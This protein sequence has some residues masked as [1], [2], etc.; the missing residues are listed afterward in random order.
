MANDDKN[1]KFRAVIDSG[2][3]DRAISGIQQKMK[4]LQQEISQTQQASQTVARDPV[5]GKFASD[6]FKASQERQGQGLQQDILKQRQEIQSTRERVEAKKKELEVLKEEKKLKQESGELDKEAVKTLERKIEMNQ[7]LVDNLNKVGA[8]QSRDL[9]SMLGTAQQAG[10]DVGMGQQNMGG[11]SAE[12]IGQ[13][14]G[15]AANARAYRGMGFGRGS[16]RMLSAIGSPMAVAG[17]VLGGIG[18][19]AST[20]API[21]DY[22]ATRDNRTALALGQAG[23]SA[24]QEMMR[25]AQGDGFENIMR[26]P[27]RQMG[28]DAAAEEFENRRLRDV[29]RGTPGIVGGLGGA[30]AGAKMGAAVGGMAGSVVPLVG[31]AVGA[32]GGAIVGGI[33]GYMLGN[34][35][36]GGGAGQALRAGLNTR[37]YQ[38]ELMAEQIVRGRQLEQSALDRDVTYRASMA[39]MR[40]NRGLFQGFQTQFGEENPMALGGMLENIQQA[41]ITGQTGLRLAQ[42][43]QSASGMTMGAE[44]VGDIST[45]FRLQ[46]AGL[47]NAAQAMGAMRGLNATFGGE[48]NTDEAF[49]KLFSE[50]V[51]IGVDDSSMVQELRQFTDASIRLSQST[52]MG[53]EEAAGEVARG[54]VGD[55]SQFGLQSQMSARQIERG[56]STAGGASLDYKLAF[57]GT[58]QGKEMLG[59]M[60]ED[61]DSVLQF[62]NMD[63]NN[64]SEGNPVIQSMMRQMGVDNIQEFRRRKAEFDLTGAFRRGPTRE[65]FRELTGRMSGMSSEEASDFLRSVEGSDMYQQFTA[66]AEAENLAFRS[67]F[68]TQMQLVG[69]FAD[70]LNPDSRNRQNELASGERVRQE[71]LGRGEESLGAVFERGDAAAGLQA[72]RTANLPG[73]D[74]RSPF[75]IF[76]E[77]S[78]KYMEATDKFVQAVSDMQKLLTDPKTA[79]GDRDNAREALSILIRDAFGNVLSE[80]EGMGASDAEQPSATTGRGR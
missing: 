2:E 71:M 58:Q 38:A 34:N 60:A 7:R 10:I 72:Q 49:K 32:A 75:E 29:M 64:I 54:M 35:I 8:A 31:N 23:S 78:S 16:A 4:K 43:Q 6:F 30:L 44:D 73:Q 26:S 48:Q 55:F 15:R 18:A 45:S 36:L 12:R 22:F 76:S 5:V 59:N 42:A 74:G 65:Q 46:Q 25:A 17:G 24:N 28:Q 61:T 9:S 11:L 68:G 69:R 40:N 66:S 52:G 63:I 33:G 51:A 20:A 77:G 21:M 39:Y 57:A 19:A 13:L 62:A 1:I 67:Q 3:F 80:R 79:E 70:V 41:G 37:E 47:S 56:L 27:F 53:V 50:A 14:R